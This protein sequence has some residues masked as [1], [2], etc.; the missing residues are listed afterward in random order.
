[1]YLTHKYAMVQMMNLLQ[2]SDT[3]WNFAVVEY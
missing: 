3:L 1:M 2:N